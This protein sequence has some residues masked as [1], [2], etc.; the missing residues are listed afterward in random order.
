[1]SKAL[2]TGGTGFIGS[3]IVR[4]LL[5]EKMAV[6]CL[7][8]PSSNRANLA[9][10]EVEY[11]LGDL[12]D[13]PSLEMA[14]RDCDLL[15]HAAADYRLWARDPAEL[16][17]VNVE[18]SRA[19]FEAA[20]AAHLQKIVFTS[21]V[22]AVGRPPA[23][24][25]PGIGTEALDPSSEQLIGA[26]KKSKFASDRLARDFAA[27]GL[28]IV[29]VN[30]AAPIGPRDIKPTPTGKII[31]DLLNGRLPAYLETG[32][33][34]VDVEDVAAGHWLAAQKGRVGERYILGHEN[35]SFKSFLDLVARIARVPAPRVRIPYPAAWLAGALST[36]LS[37][38]TGKE[39][40]VPLDGVR[41]AHS[42]MFYD[43]SKAVRELGLPQTPIEEA[44]VK[45]VAW[46][47]ENGY[48]RA[49]R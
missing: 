4:R 35:L 49:Q 45:A 21:S 40:A 28:P 36:G 48:V 37:R 34:F 13:R 47:R 7:V 38:F 3:H 30:P 15:F 17:R 33:N 8:R 26:Y 22:A 6:R 31:V 43:A 5:K 25:R 32:M 16:A 2:V 23:N 18:G 41:M 27:Q 20:G 9:G 39:P 46:F 29:L 12:R 42:T 24:G 19:L 10:L 1:M 14:L 11:V 44:V